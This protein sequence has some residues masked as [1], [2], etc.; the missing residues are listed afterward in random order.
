MTNKLVLSTLLLLLL[1]ATLHGSVSA[2]TTTNNDANL[3]G[4]G[5]SRKLQT[6]FEPFK[7]SQT[8]PLVTKA[9][10]PSKAPTVYKVP[11]TKAPST[12]P[13]SKSPVVKGSGGK[14]SSSSNAKDTVPPVSKGTPSPKGDETM[15]VEESMAAS[16]TSE[17]VYYELFKDTTAK[18]L[19]VSAFLVS[20]KSSFTPLSTDFE[21]LAKVVR[22]VFEDIY[23]N[24]FADSGEFDFVGV[25]LPRYTVVGPTL[26]DFEVDVYFSNKNS[27]PSLFQVES[28]A[29][30]GFQPNADFYNLLLG[31][32]RGMQSRFYSQAETV[33]YIS[34]MQ[35]LND[36]VL[37]LSNDNTYTS[38]QL[39][40]IIMLTLFGACLMALFAIL[41]WKRRR[42]QKRTHVHDDEYTQ[43][44]L[45]MGNK[46][47][48][49]I[50]E[51]ASHDT[52]ATCMS[53]GDTQMP[54]PR[55]PM[56]RFT[57]APMR[58]S[59]QPLVPPVK[60]VAHDGD[61]DEDEFML[62]ENLTFDDVA[63]EDET[64]ADAKQCVGEIRKSAYVND[65]MVTNTTQPRTDALKH[66]GELSKQSETSNEALVEPQHEPTELQKQV[67]VAKNRI[68][69]I[70]K[71]KYKNK[72]TRSVPVNPTYPGSPKPWHTGGL[73]PVPESPESPYN[74]S[75][76]DP[77][78]RIFQ[79]STPVSSKPTAKASKPIQNAAI[80]DDD[81]ASVYTID[82]QSSATPEFLKKFK[83]MGLKRPKGET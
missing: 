4:K 42:H 45:K 37:S 22:T 66:V 14:G 80:A 77:P 18:S 82:S 73:H 3:R 35:D 74:A 31:K 11:K 39:A 43:V 33:Q 71:S 41:L 62:D 25:F 38:G 6:F 2:Q 50:K 34:D 28:V 15:L 63:L 48:D 30:E 64:V 9:P 72:V 5:P 69:E 56:S 10:T 27:V 47:D 54:A 24:K 76:F 79:A 44:Q 51:S 68:A 75:P 83:Q 1:G 13:P 36:A 65:R 12:S 21:E 60:T 52:R 26:V 20:T 46:N 49:F 17:S 78:Q 58:R 29:K 61:S 8:E 67:A 57:V 19:P 23:K 81:N 55:S 16:G 53:D 32:M 70:N 59:P 7:V 40:L